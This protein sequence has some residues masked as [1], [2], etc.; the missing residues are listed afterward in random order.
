ML[1][2][3]HLPAVLEAAAKNRK[4]Y[5]QLGLQLFARILLSQPLRI[6]FICQHGFSVFVSLELLAGPSWPV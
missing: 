6:T 5:E 1:L 3:A 4:L 2:L